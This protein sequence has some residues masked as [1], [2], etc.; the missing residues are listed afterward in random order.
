MLQ[1]EFVDFAPALSSP[2]VA[3]SNEG[4]FQQQKSNLLVGWREIASY[5]VTALFAER[6]GKSREEHVTLGRRRREKKKSQVRGDTSSGVGK[7]FF[8]FF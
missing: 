8:F 3:P 1:R 7:L 6:P 5:S 2:D 4:L